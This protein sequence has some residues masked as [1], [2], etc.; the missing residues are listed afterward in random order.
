MQTQSS[1]RWACGGN[2]IPAFSEQ[3]RGKDK[4]DV[5]LGEI[6]TQQERP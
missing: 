2:C 6:R 3:E 5:L 4:V 1:S